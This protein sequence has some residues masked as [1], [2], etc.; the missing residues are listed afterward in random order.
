[1]AFSMVCIVANK[2]LSLTTRGV[3]TQKNEACTSLL[4][5][6]STRI[7]SPAERLKQ[8]LCFQLAE[9]LEMAVIFLGGGTGK[10]G[11]SLVSRTLLCSLGSTFKARQ[12]ERKSTED[13]RPPCTVK[14]LS[15]QPRTCQK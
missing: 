14:S 4:V 12:Q 15:V 6:I 1:M 8:I 9:V 5:L 7:S 10:N 2:T 11:T 3:C 13:S